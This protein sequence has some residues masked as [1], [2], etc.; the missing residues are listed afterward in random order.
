MSI[1]FLRRWPDRASTP[2]LSAPHA[3]SAPQGWMCGRAYRTPFGS[4]WSPWPGPRR[5]RSRCRGGC[6]RRTRPSTHAARD[7]RPE[8]GTRSGKAQAGLGPGRAEAGLGPGRAEA[9][10]G[11]GRAEAGL[12]PG[13]AEAGSGLRALRSPWP[14]FVR[15]ALPALSPSCAKP[16]LRSARPQ[17]AGALTVRSR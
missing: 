14:V 2:P 16:F 1:I 7:M 15:E 13:S 8:V 6:S 5:T 3:R 11:P 10:L 4:R 12:G 9:G 17:V